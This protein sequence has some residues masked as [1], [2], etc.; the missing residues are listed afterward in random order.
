M[1]ILYLIYLH[2]LKLNL[3][4]KFKKIKFIY[5]KWHQ[6]KSIDNEIIK[7]IFG[8][9]SAIKIKKYVFY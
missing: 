2:K 6:N 1:T 7:K 3:F 9:Y 8:S 4:I 5:K